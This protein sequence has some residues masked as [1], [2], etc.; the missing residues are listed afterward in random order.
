MKRILLLIAACLPCMVTAEDETEPTVAV[1]DI[2][3]FISES[4]NIPSSPFS[5]DFDTELPMT[6]HDL[7]TGLEQAVSDE[8]VEAIV[9][10]I[11]DAGLG[12]A[13]IIEI[14]DQLLAA[15]EAGKDVW[16]YSDYYDNASAIVG[17]AAN[18]FALMPEAIVDF[19]GIHY[20]AMYFKGLLDKAGLQADVVHIGDFKSF[21]E[22]FYRTG[23]SEFSKKQT[24][25]LIDGLFSEIVQLVA[26]GRKVEAEKVKGLIDRGDF[27]AEQAKQAGLVDE[28]Q[29]RTEFNRTL[30]E[31]YADANFEHD[32]GIPGSPIDEIEGIFDLFKLMF[33]D[34]GDGKQQ[35]GY[36]A[37]VV[38]EGAITELSIAPVRRAILEKLKD[39][40]A[41]GLVL[42]VDS[43]GGCAMASEILWEATRQWTDSGRPL[44]VSMGDVA[45]SGGYYVSAGADRIFAQPG[46]LTGSIGVVG[47]KFVV[48]EGLEKLGITTHSTQ[49]GKNADA[50]SMVSPF[51][52]EQ[53]EMLRDSMREVYATF[54]QRVEE[55]RGER[56]EAKLETMAGG[57]VFTGR[58]ALELGLV[59][60]MGGLR[61]AVAWVIQKA[62]LDEAE[63]ILT[64]RPKSFFE[65]LFYEPEYDE[66]DEL[67]K[68]GQGA[69]GVD[70]M[71]TAA[72]QEAGLQ[73]LPPAMRAKV[74]RA[75]GCMQAIGESR[76]QLIG[77]DLR[78]DW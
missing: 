30:R 75:Y 76:V 1:Y 66:D 71:L 18:H 72:M 62:E 37:V 43:P 38:L 36:V 74:R 57:R 35:D 8:Q 39:E 2:Q 23:P 46:T 5:I 19:A 3:G 32:Y 49:R 24:E 20:E 64:P 40:N 69:S 13:Q 77:P 33:S 68:M 54:K 70:A 21:G 78:L 11:D 52:P 58:R 15:Q 56:L 26:D 41:K 12:F 63:S 34:G 50:Y 10:E 16:F 29:Y 44:A 51:T 45:A 47:M 60:E 14:R 61:D 7:I 53:T 67:V 31:T 28:L 9:I 17:S 73:V 59:D 55:G 22:E 27:T 65:G 6:F 25:E 48:G 4:G 42:R